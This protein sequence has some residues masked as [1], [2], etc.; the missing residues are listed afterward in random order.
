VLVSVTTVGI[1][2]SGWAVLFAVPM[3]AVVMTLFDVILRDVDPAEEEVP[4]V[5]FSPKED[6]G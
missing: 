6:T 2:F 4:A 1:L 5:I 3:A